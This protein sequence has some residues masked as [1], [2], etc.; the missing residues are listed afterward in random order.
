M[1]LNLC[2]F[3]KN[4]DKVYYINHNGSDHVVSLSKFLENSK[5]FAKEFRK[6]PKRLI[7]TSLHS[8]KA[9]NTFFQMI[10]GKNVEIT[11]EIANELLSIAKEW[12]CPK[13]LKTLDNTLHNNGLYP[14][15]IHLKTIDGNM[16]LIYIKEDTNMA[17][18][19]KQIAEITNIP[20]EKQNLVVYGQNINGDF[21]V[22]NL[23]NN[24]TIYMV[25]QSI[26]TIPIYVK[27]IVG[28]SFKIDIYAHSKIEDI[29]KILSQYSDIP[30]DQI[31]LMF[32]GKPLEED[33]IMDDYNIKKD[34]FLHYLIRQYS[35]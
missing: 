17:S 30:R 32:N 19:K 7:I 18:L 3:N 16:Y 9:M 22:L 6:H 35:D 29:I 24:D 26:R 1:Q 13:L 25:E 11:K 4:L 8:T 5:F 34:A 14:R 23:L 2:E 15:R 27:D 21:K 20:I 12:E 28:K 10:Q 33:K 31:R